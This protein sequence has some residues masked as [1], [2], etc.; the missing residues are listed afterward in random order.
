M[1]KVIDAF[2]FFNELD[3]LELRLNELYPVV[4]YF[5]IVESMECHGSANTK[6]AVLADNWS[7]VKPF[8]SKIRYS[9]LERL[10]PPYDANS[11]GKD[12]MSNVSA[13]GRENF[14]RNALMTGISEVASQD[15]IIIIS[16]CDEIPRAET[17]RRALP[18]FQSGIHQLHMDFFYYNVNR[19]IGPWARSAA[20]TLRQ[21][22]AAGGPQSLRNTTGG[23]GDGVGGAYPWVEN[24]GWHFS[25]F[26]GVERIRT[27]LENFAHSGDTVCRN[28]VADSSQALSDIASG[29]DVMHVPQGPCIGPNHEGWANNFTTWREANDARLPAYFL[30]NPEKYIHFT[31]AFFGRQRNDVNI[32]RALN[33][34]GNDPGAHRRGELEWLARK[35]SVRKCIV[36]IGSWRGH[37]T[38]A[39][40]ENTGGIVYSVDPWTSTPEMSPDP[41]YPLIQKEPEWLMEDFRRNVG[42]ALL[43]KTVRPMRMKSL[44]AAAVFSRQGIKFDMIFIDA[45]HDYDSVRDDILAWRPLL[46]A[47]GLLCGHDMGFEGVARALSELVPEARSVGAGSIWAVE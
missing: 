47:N 10:E 33:L 36:E 42:P 38:I 29:R 1:P 16:D 2:T 43:E 25:C 44:D 17:M 14:Q 28:F 5:V 45:A 24:C 13:W 23:R 9:V 4:D 20:G 27:K 22:Q 19:Y 30:G 39:M 40:A 6:R 18:I 35:A 26:G 21:V 34:S 7:I 41:F 15:D 12:W 11:P 37:S 31:D 32:E 46:A 3:I 8:E